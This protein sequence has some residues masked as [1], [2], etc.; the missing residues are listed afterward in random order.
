MI[1]ATPRLAF[2]AV[3]FG[4]GRPH[5]QQRRRSEN[6]SRECDLTK[7]LRIFVALALSVLGTVGARAEIVS[8]I[9]GRVLK[10]ED[11]YL[12]GETIVIEL[13]DGGTMVVPA[14]RV[15]RVVA[16]EVEDDPEPLAAPA[17]C[18]WAWGGENLPDEIPYREQIQRAAEAA[19]IHP[20]LL[21]AVVRAESNFNPLAVSRAGAA[22][23][24][25]LMPATAADRGVRDVFEPA[26]NLRGGAE[27][28]RR[29]LGRFGSLTLALAAYNA[30]PAAVERHGGV[31]PYRETRQYVRKV[32]L[33]YCGEAA[34]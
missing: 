32:T 10:A 2:S 24:A 13:R 1:K 15:E 27:Y 7:L 9:D 5:R 17:D 8:F 22:G 18:P 20:W 16:D 34:E 23:L 33:W 6:P 21:V 29:L 25:Q 14:T 31:P 30:G 4:A 19:G 28:L 3:V 12:E 11:A 26:D